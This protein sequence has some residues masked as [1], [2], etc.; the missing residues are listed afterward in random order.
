MA[1][2][3]KDLALQT[4][5]LSSSAEAERQAVETQLTQRIEELR[6]GVAAVRADAAGGEAAALTAGACGCACGWSRAQKEKAIDELKAQVSGLEL[7]LADAKRNVS[8]LTAELQ[9]VRGE[10][11][12][13]ICACV[14]ARVALHRTDGCWRG[15]S[16]GLF[17]SL[18]LR[19]RSRA[20]D[21]QGRGREAGCQGEGAERADRPAG[22]AAP[23]PGGAA[24]RQGTRRAARPCST[25]AQWLGG[26][27]TVWLSAQADDAARTEAKLRADL[28]DREKN[29]AEVKG[30]HGAG[31]A[32]AR[33]G[34]ARAVRGL[35]RAREPSSPPALYANRARG[36]GVG[37]GVGVSWAWLT[38][39][40]RAD[41]VSK[42]QG[43]LEIKERGFQVR[44]HPSALHTAD[45]ALSAA[46]RRGRALT[47]GWAQREKAEYERKMEVLQKVQANLSG[48]LT[49]VASQANKLRESVARTPRLAP[50]S[51]ADMSCWRRLL[52]C[53]L[54]NVAEP[55]CVAGDAVF[56]CALRRGL[57]WTAGASTPSRSS[58]RARPPR[59]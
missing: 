44:T 57:T 46:K 34:C 21:R 18:S 13:C 45:P 35:R 6:A 19:A 31:H 43:A 20:G 15:P 37:V 16:A 36:L 52:C 11:I 49:T 5:K 42:L 58:R 50:P 4:S 17:H 9:A 47:S 59:S 41:E 14:H 55:T 29:V 32:G 12:H 25:R 3:R 40:P 30:K 53:A 54:R 56:L 1:E 22:G 7:Q 39:A 28:A 26:A 10:P 48:H 24:G 2:A 8:T 23:R 27:L 33:V 38:R 51:R